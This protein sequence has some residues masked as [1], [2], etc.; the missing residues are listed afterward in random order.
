MLVVAAVVAAGGSDAD[1]PR[2]AKGADDTAAGGAQASSWPPGTGLLLVFAGMSY[3]A[4]S[5]R[6][7][8]WPGAGGHRRPGAA[9]RSGPGRLVVP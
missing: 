7:S 3:P 9:D 5:A 8:R 1:E 2:M 4:R 6:G